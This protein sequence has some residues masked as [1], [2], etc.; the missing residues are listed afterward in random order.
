MNDTKSTSTSVTKILYL[1]DTKVN[2]NDDEAF[3]IKD[4]NF[5]KHEEK[6]DN[7]SNNLT[8]IREKISHIWSSG[9]F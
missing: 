2:N 3:T 5:R 1:E 8:E 6:R 4:S 9:F 7:E